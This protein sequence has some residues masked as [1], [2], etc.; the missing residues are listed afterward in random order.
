MRVRCQRICILS[1]PQWR[2]VQIHT[3]LFGQS[4]SCALCEFTLLR[5][6]LCIGSILPNW[7]SWVLD[8]IVRVFGF[9]LLDSYMATFY[10]FPLLHFRN[11]DNLLFSH[12]LEF[13]ECFI[14]YF[15]SYFPI[16]ETFSFALSSLSTLLSLV[17]WN[18]LWHWLVHGVSWR[19]IFHNGNW[20]DSACLQRHRHSVEWHALNSLGQH[21]P[22]VFPSGICAVIEVGNHLIK[23]Y[24]S[25]MSITCF[26]SSLGYLS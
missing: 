20:E 6:I 9:R 13:I 2:S 26:V 7:K 17:M 5:G 10:S 25:V 1:T 14:V 3:L 24:C 16:H 4:F 15:K 11:A 8:Q 12:H 22:S 21:C 19:C 18:N 23:L